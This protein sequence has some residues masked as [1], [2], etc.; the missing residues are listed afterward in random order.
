MATAPTMIT[1]MTLVHRLI[2]AAR[3]NEGMT[4]VYTGLL[5]GISTGAAAGGWTVD[6]LGS[7]S[8]YLTP[9]TAAALAFAIAWAGRDRL[10]PRYGAVPD[11]SGR[12]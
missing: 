11:P 9:A 10:R 3:L 12:S 8:A 1:G 2:P 4:T 7:T 5:I 6:H